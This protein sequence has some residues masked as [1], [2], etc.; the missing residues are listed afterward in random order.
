VVASP[1][2]HLDGELPVPDLDVLGLLVQAISIVEPSDLLS[3][4]DIG[5]TVEEYEVS[6]R[7]D[8]EVG[9]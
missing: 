2:P 9:S 8:P 7:G 5:P 3:L 4:P 1:S 6:R